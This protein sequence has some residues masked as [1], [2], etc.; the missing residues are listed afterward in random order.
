MP[1]YVN[2]SARKEKKHFDFA[3]RRG[4]IVWPR[5]RSRARVRRFIH[6]FAASHSVKLRDSPSLFFSFLDSPRG[7]YN[8]DGQA[9][10]ARRRAGPK[11]RSTVRCNICSRDRIDVRGGKGGEGKKEKKTDSCGPQVVCMK[12]RSRRCRIY[13]R[14]CT[15]CYPTERD[16]LVIPFVR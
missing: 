1:I 3:L 7:S 13:E 15:V 16:R 11:N 2:G 14:K 5:V 6:K 8:D 10:I 9:I 12:L 4:L